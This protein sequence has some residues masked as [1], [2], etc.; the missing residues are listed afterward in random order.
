MGAQV[1]KRAKPVRPGDEIYMPLDSG[2]WVPIVWDGVRLRRRHKATGPTLAEIGRF[3]RDQVRDC[4]NQRCS[5]CWHVV[6]AEQLLVDGLVHRTPKPRGRKGLG[7][8]TSAHSARRPSYDR[9][10]AR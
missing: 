4:P 10:R 8:S 1:T 3:V 7:R 6:I 2:R 9:P 5:G